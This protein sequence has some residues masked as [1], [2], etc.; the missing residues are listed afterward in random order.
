MSNI[1]L[2]M[3]ITHRINTLNEDI[4]KQIFS[5]SD[6]IEFDIRDSNGHIIVQHDPF[7]DG[8]LLTDFVKYCPSDKFYIVNVKSEGIEQDAINILES[9][10]ISTFFL[11]DCSIPSIIKLKN[12]GER[13]TCVRFSEYESLDTIQLMKDVVTWVW[14]DVFTKMPLN[15]DIY[16]ILKSYNLKLCLVSPE[17]QNQPE[18]ITH[19]KQYLED[20][21]I[22]LDAICSKHYN[23]IK[24]C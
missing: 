23:K 22:I 7:L 20:N 12:K 6:G 8:Q 3:F 11:L 10:N 18:K 21:N 4:S 2:G 15:K 17:L 14:I 19:Y 9:H 1:T 5:I 16:T 13:R 24:W